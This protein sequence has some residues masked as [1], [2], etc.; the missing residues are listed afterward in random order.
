VARDAVYVRAGGLCQ[1]R[2]PVCVGRGSEVQHLRGR[3]GPLLTDLDW[4]RWTCAPCHQHAHMH[5]EEAYRNGWLVKRLGGA[6]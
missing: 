3:V 5:V 1:L 6:A 4:M 2:T